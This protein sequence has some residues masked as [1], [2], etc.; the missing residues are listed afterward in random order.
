MFEEKDMVKI[1][2]EEVK[3]LKRLLIEAQYMLERERMKIY[4][5]NNTWYN[6]IMYYLGWPL[7]NYE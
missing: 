6:F 2:K 3:V 7:Y 4:N 1:N 5:E